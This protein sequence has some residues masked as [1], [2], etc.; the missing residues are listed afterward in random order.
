MNSVRQA[1]TIF[2]A[3]LREI[4]DEA[5]YMRFLSRTRLPSSATTYASFCRERDS[6]Q[7]RRH[8]CC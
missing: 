6:M 1:L 3:A 2:W 4:F 5:A 8:R 7:A